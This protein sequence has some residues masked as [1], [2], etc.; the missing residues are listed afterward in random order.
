MTEGYSYHRQCF[1]EVPP[2][3]LALWP[4]EPRSH[5][6]PIPGVQAGLQKAECD[7]SLFPYSSNCGC[8]SNTSSA[9]RELCDLRPQTESLWAL[10]PSPVN[11]AHI[12]HLTQWLR[13]FKTKLKYLALVG[14]QMG[15]HSFHGNP[16]NSKR[17][18][19]PEEHTG[20]LPWVSPASCCDPLRE[21]LVNLFTQAVSKWP[22]RPSREGKPVFGAWGEALPA[23]DPECPG[24]GP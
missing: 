16:M 6:P 24:L 1:P 8:G 13:E 22:G 5:T 18:Q 3:I 11:R 15:R 10:V 23:V 20:P 7:F 2:R 14:A 4:W 12:I 21:S 9:H 17:L 19:R